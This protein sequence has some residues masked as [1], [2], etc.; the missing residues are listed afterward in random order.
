MIKSREL[1]DP[2]SCMNRAH[3]TEMTFVLLGRDAAAPYAIRAW[4]RERVGLGKN[5]WDDPQITE[6]FECCREMERAQAV[7]RKAQVTTEDALRLAEAFIMAELDERTA[8]LLGVEIDYIASAQDALDAVRAA[9]ANEHAPVEPIDQ[10]NFR[11]EVIR[12]LAGIDRKLE[13]FTGEIKR[14]ADVLDQIIA[15][16][17]TEST[18]IDQV[19]AELDQ[20]A[21][22]IAELKAGTISPTDPRFQTILDNQTRFNTALKAMLPAA[23]T[24]GDPTDPAPPAGPAPT[25]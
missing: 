13:H 21:A 14:M 4:A 3:D 20:Q 9:I 16:Q 5:R 12:A 25:V 18:E 2:N 24:G 6:A 8:C 22:D 23:A 19:K 11:R 7:A 15:G 10:Q 1:N 17:A